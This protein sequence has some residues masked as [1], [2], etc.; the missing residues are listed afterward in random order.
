LRGIF[1]KLPVKAGI[2]VRINATL[3]SQGISGPVKEACR[4]AQRTHPVTS[5]P[6]GADFVGLAFHVISLRKTG[7]ALAKLDQKLHPAPL[8][9]SARSRRADYPAPMRGLQRCT[10]TSPIARLAE[11]MANS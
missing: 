5:S 1:P 10:S 8:M 11:N 7:N 3:E 2:V 9:M 6:C 4:Y